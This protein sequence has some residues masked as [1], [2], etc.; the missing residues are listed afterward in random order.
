M[1][2]TWTIA[3]LAALL[4][5][6]NVPAELISTEIKIAAAD[7][8]NGDRFGDA[9]GISGDTVVVCAFLDSDAG[10]DSGSAYVFV[11]NGNTWTQ[12]QKL[13]A[14]DA[15][16]GDL[17]GRSVAISGDSIVVSADAKAS[18]AGAAYVFVRNGGVWTQQQK[19]TASDAAVNSYFGSSLA[20][21]GDTIMVGATGPGSNAGAVY[22]FTRS[23]GVWT[24][25]Q[26]LIA[27][28]PVAD[29]FFGNS[30]AI[31]GETI[32]VG[33][34]GK[35]GYTGA[36]YVFVLTG[37]NWIQQ[38]KLTAADRG[39]H[40]LFGHLLDISGETIVVGA[41]QSDD[42]GSK[43]G[44]AYTFV[45]SGT[46]WTQQ[47]K[48]TANDAASDQFF[49][50]AVGISG[51][52]VVAGASGS[53]SAYLFSRS[54]SL[55]QQQGKLIPSD[56][57]GG[58]NN[59]GFIGIQGTNVVGGGQLNNNGRGAAYLYDLQE[60][61]DYAVTKIAAPKKI[62]FSATV[63]NV[64]AKVSVT[65]QNLD[66]TITIIPDLGTLADL[67]E[68]TAQTLGAC[69]DISPQLVAP[70][71]TFPFAW[72]PKKKLTLNY[73]A[74]FD[75]VNDPLLT[76]K[77]ETHSDYRFVATVH[78]TAIGGTDRVPANDDCPR[79]A[80]PVTGDKGCDKGIEVLTDVFLK[81]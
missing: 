60:V 37:T 19:L 73:T 31:S 81:Q 7:G 23:G 45:R 62:T 26:K 38:A 59:F 55:W 70:A 8:A 10:A 50:N 42:K 40:D 44:S 67:V 64:A 43:A 61:H 14:S 28:D 20:I 5:W 15:A 25:Q 17:F 11:R 71:V 33:A 12:Q 69:P 27:A 76:S 1:K 47:A 63:S 74:A 24:E 66:Q 56:A 77:T 51:D 30:L 49:G 80:N 79:P 72:K 58:P 78:A 4:A 34:D 22:V 46:T 39:L 3:M 54:G 68:V 53:D 48:L 32:A 9:V 57:L 16:A 2:L 75:C 13:I 18:S 65:I 21:S 41:P 6:T 29:D 36:A 52:I 35:D